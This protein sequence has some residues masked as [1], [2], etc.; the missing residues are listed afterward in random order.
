MLPKEG[1]KKI[2]V[3]LFYLVVGLLFAYLFFKYLFYALLPF[4]IANVSIS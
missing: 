4:L 1:Y 3:I 2:A